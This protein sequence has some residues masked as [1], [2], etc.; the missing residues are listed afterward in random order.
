MSERPQI[1]SSRILKSYLHCMDARYPEADIDIILQHA[2]IS[3]Y[4]LDDPGHW[5]NQQQVDRFFEKTVEITGNPAIAREAGRFAVLNETAGP[6]RQLAL[7]LLKVSSIYLLLAKLY[8]MLSRG[9]L[10]KTQKLGPNQVQIIVEPLPDVMESPHQCENRIGVFEA[11]S[12]LF[13]DTYAKIEH[14]TNTT[15]QKIIIDLLCFRYGLNS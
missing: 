14:Y 13:T 2:D 10:V 15:P 7:G 12:T 3:K 8:P 6:I 9:A 11:L 5:F 1:Y 4:E